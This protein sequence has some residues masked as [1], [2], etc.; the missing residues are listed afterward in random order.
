LVLLLAVGALAVTFNSYAKTLLQ[1]TAAPQMRGRVMALWLIAWQG[2][3][4]VGAPLIGL[5][6]ALL[7]ARWALLVGGIAALAAGILTR[8]S[9]SEA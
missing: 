5:V 1:L 3:T 9:G 4:V 6:A 7:G 2:S 8:V